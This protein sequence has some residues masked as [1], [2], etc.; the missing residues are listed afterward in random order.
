MSGVSITHAYPD[1]SVV[2]VEVEVA[3]DFPQ[4]LAE[5]EARCMSLYRAAVPD[6]EAM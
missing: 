3:D 6:V 1:G 4:C 2:R 5:A